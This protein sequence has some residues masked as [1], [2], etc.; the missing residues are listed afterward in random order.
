[1]LRSGRFKNCFH[2]SLRRAANT[3]EILM[4]RVFA[5]LPTL[6]FLS[7][8]SLATCWNCC[9]CKLINSHSLA[10]KRIGLGIDVILM[11]AICLL[12]HISRFIMRFVGRWLRNANGRK[13]LNTVSYFEAIS[14]LHITV[15]IVL[16]SGI[17]CEM[18]FM[19]SRT[20]FFP[21]SLSSWTM[22]FLQHFRP[23]H[24]VGLFYPFF[25]AFLLWCEP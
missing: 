4:L 16:C 7:Q 18:L 24:L 21:L 6:D 25:L 17:R 2:K 5:V 1:M 15:V 9:G 3:Q 20:P 10:L 8:N 22:E 14:S 12:W 19:I 11:T 23:K 13:F